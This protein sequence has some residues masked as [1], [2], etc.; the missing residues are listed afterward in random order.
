LF[1]C[2]LLGW[3]LELDGSVA[4]KGKFRLLQ[5]QSPGN[6]IAPDNCQL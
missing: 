3:A 4:H 1:V 2:T 5:L 6:R